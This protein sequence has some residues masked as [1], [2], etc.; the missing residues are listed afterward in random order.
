MHA[1][2]HAREGR[3]QGRGLLPGDIQLPVAHLYGVL[4]PA[5]GTRARCTAAWQHSAGAR[6]MHC[7]DCACPG[8]LRARSWGRHLGQALACSAQRPA[9]TL[10]SCL[11]PF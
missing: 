2:L 9:Q 6:A 5:L 4:Q 8:D 3:P 10:A 11:R 7:V 1:P